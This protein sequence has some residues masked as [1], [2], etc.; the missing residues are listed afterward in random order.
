MRV[1]WVYLVTTI[2]VL[3]EDNGLWETKNH[4]F[5]KSFNYKKSRLQDVAFLP[6]AYFVFTT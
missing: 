3:S 2:I 6:S 4:R 1:I 5:S